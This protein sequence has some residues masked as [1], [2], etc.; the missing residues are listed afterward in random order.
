VFPAVSNK[1]GLGDKQKKLMNETSN[2]SGRCHENFLAPSL[3]NRTGKWRSEPINRW[4]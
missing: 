1:R 4:S 2:I 3:G